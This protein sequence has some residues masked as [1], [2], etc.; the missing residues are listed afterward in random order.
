MEYEKALDKNELPI[1]QMKIVTLQEKA[2]LVINDN[3][4]FYAINNRCPHMGGSLGDGELLGTMI[5]CPRHGSKYEVVTGKNVGEAKIGI[6]KIRV[7]DAQTYPV[8]VEG[9]DVLIGM[10]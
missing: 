3:G 7:K 9:N 5:T 4:T 1:G 10:E 2:I 8:K 6:L